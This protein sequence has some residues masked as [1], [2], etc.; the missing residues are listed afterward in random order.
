MQFFYSCRLTLKHEQ[1]KLCKSFS[2]AFKW[3][4]LHLLW[5]CNVLQKLYKHGYMNNLHRN[6][7]LV[8]HELGPLNL[9]KIVFSIF[10]LSQ[11]MNKNQL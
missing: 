2:N 3:K 9:Y 11:S 4:L 10:L 1:N 7:P 6:L 5:K 8:F